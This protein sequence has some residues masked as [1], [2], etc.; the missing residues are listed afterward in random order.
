MLKPR[1][2]L[3][4][5]GALAGGGLLAVVL[6]I[7]GSGGSR[8]AA[9]SGAT[10]ADT[11]TGGWLKSHPHVV[12][13]EGPGQL[14]P[15][16]AAASY[17][18]GTESSN[19]Q[20]PSDAQVKRELAQL[21]VAGLGGAGSYVNPFA[22]VRGLS[23]SRI[24]MGVDYQGVGPVLALGSGTVFVT[25][26]PGWPGGTF[27]GITLDSGPYAGR[28]YFVAEDVRPTVRPGERV[29]AGQVI[30]TMYH[31]SAGIET[32]WA[33]GRSDEPLA[34]ALGQQNKAGDPGAWSSAAVVSFDRVLVSVGAPS[35]IPQGVAVH[36]K[37]PPGYP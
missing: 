30:G 22:H 4:V 8:P 15:S 13:A 18:Y 10:A 37:M 1:R 5:F 11:A 7:A 28:A 27:I 26:G 16:E 9:R 36:G 32:G 33:S 25:Q 19:F 20:P 23:P 31:G 12:I 14:S 21:N 3:R 2:K 34:A 29:Q 17:Q 6:L 24:D 35:G